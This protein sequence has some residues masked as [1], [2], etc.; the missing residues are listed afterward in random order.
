MVLACYSRLPVTWSHLYI[1]I[2]IF[3]SLCS[4]TRTCIRIYI[5]TSIT[6]GEVWS[7]G[8]EYE[9][10]KSRDPADLTCAYIYIH[11][12]SQRSSYN[13]LKEKQKEKKNKENEFKKQKN[14][15]IYYTRRVWTDVSLSLMSPFLPLVMFF[16]FFYFSMLLYFLDASSR[17]FCLRIVIQRMTFIHLFDFVYMKWIVEYSL[18]M[19][20]ATS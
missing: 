9:L 11:L 14:E 19:H 6:Q 16:I 20:S 4:W 1:G 18:L 3:S 17:H 10:A 5:H 2:Y 8:R 13:I 15:R 7:Q 12:Y